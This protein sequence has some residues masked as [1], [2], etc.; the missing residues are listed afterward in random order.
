MSTG[1]PFPDTSLWGIHAPVI[2]LAG[3]HRNTVLRTEPGWSPAVVFK[4]TRRSLEALSWLAAPQ[5]AALKAGFFVP[6]L[7]V[8]E[9][10]QVM[11][12]GWTCE[13]FVEGIPFSRSDMPEIAAMLARFHS[14]AANIAQRPGFA[15]SQELLKRGKGGDVDLSLMPDALVRRCRSAWAALENDSVGVI[16]ADLSPSNLMHLPTGQP[17]LLDW[18]ETRVDNR[19]FDSVQVATGAVA[20]DVKQATCA[21]EIACSWHLEPERARRLAARCFP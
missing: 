3:G 10:G 16:H 4:S 15:S 21:W 2:A 12:D 11:E 9:R 14:E 6:E 19:I 7:L 5:A 17:A 13:P 8:S 20:Q 1:A 18:D